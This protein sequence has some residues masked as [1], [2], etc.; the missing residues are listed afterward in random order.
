MITINNKTWTKE[1]LEQLILNAQDIAMC[2]RMD[3]DTIEEN[4]DTM[5]YETY[6]NFSNLY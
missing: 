1:E 2:I 6:N 5:D 3:L 4:S